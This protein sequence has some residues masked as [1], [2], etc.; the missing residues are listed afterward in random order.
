MKTNKHVIVLLVL[1]LC[2]GYKFA[3]VSHKINLYFS[4]DF[5]I[6]KSQKPTKNKPYL[7]V[8]ND[9]TILKREEL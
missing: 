7:V 6:T 5:D 9:K 1:L 2:F 3:R 4:M 8:F